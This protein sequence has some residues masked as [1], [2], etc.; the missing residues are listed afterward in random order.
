MTNEVFFLWRKCG[1]KRFWQAVQAEEPERR[2]MVL[3]AINKYS[4]S[5]LAVYISGFMTS[6]RRF[7]EFLEVPFEP[8]V[9][10]V[11]P[12][13]ITHSERTRYVRHKDVKI[14]DVHEIEQVHKTVIESP[15]YE[16]ISRVFRKFPL[17]NDPEITAMKITLIDMTNST[18]LGAHRSQVSTYDLVQLILNT[19]DFDERVRQGDPELVNLLAR[20]TGKVNLFLFATKYCTYHNVDI[21]GN[22]DYSIFDSVVAKSLPGYS[23]TATAADFVR[24]RKAYNYQAFADCI[25]EILDRNEIQIAFRRRKFDHYIWYTNR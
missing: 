17:N 23:P 22:D 25:T 10:R 4:T 5:G 20:N 2:E 21:Y 7:L 16:L 13:P 19:S 8:A 3:D 12:E 15:D 6:Y 11:H 9:L 24:W 1:Q 14:L 18:H